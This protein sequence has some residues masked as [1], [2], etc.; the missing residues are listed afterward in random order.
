MGQVDKKRDKMVKDEQSNAN[1]NVSVAANGSL[2]DEREVED[3]TRKTNAA[4]VITV[5]QQI[6]EPITTNA[7]QNEDVEMVEETE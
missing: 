4:D 3:L 1:V 2:Q 7:D 5:E 6:V